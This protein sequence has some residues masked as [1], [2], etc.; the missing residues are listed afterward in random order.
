MLNVNQKNQATDDNIKEKISNNVWTSLPCIIKKYDATSNT[1][2]VKPFGGVMING[3]WTKYPIIYHIPVIS[4]QSNGG[5]AGINQDFQEDDLG[6]KL[7]IKNN[8]QNFMDKYINESKKDL[9]GDE[10]PDNIY[11]DFRYN[12]CVFLGGL[13]PSSSSSSKDKSDLSNNAMTIYNK[14][15]KIEIFE[16]Y[17]KISSREENGASSTVGKDSIEANISDNINLILNNEI[18]K[19]IVGSSFFQ[20]SQDYVI[21]S[22]GGKQ[23]NWNGTRLFVDGNISLS[24]KINNVN[25]QNHQHYWSLNG[26]Q[27]K[28]SSPI[29]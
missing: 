28:T 8:F 21:M 26:Q 12:D 4:F 20:L 18:I 16:D 27:L 5:E 3:I 22:K 29:K 14:N 11:S 6:L 17:T 9:D 13:Y 1:V 19:A 23:V 2:N 7:F 15:S 25:V 10:E 24:G